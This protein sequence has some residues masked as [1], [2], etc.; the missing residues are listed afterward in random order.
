M[1]IWLPR[2]PLDRLVRRQDPRVSGVFAVTREIKNAKRLTHIS[3]AGVRAGLNPGMS[4]TD[5]RA[6]CPD[7]LTE[8]ADPVRE[9]LLLRALRRW[10]DRLSPWAALDGPDGLVLDISGCA[11]LYAGEDPMRAEAMAQLADMHITAQIAIADTQGA[12]WALARYGYE[13]FIAPPGRIAEAISDL[14]V[15]ALRIDPTAAISLRRIGL[16]RI[17]SLSAI[18]G[19]DL[20]RRYGLAFNQRR[21]KVLGHVPDP[22]A[23]LAADQ[24]FAARMNLPEP[25]GLQS[26]IEAVL[27]RLCISVC[28]RLERACQGARGF[29]L[30]VRCVDTGEHFLPIGFARPT[31]DI[32]LIKRQFE[33][34]LDDLRMEFGA[35]WFR[36][37]ARDVEPLKIIQ[38]DIE[39]QE[40]DEES[41]D[42]MIA[43][44]GNRLGFDRVRRFAPR[45]SHI[46]ER[47]FA[48]VEAVCVVDH[49]EWEPAERSRPLRLFRPERL[50]T[51]E[52]GRPPKR[53]SWRGQTYETRSAEGP[54]RLSPEW[55]QAVSAPVRDY[56]RVQ[57]GEGPRLWL[58]AHPSRTPPEWFVAG[59]FT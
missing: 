2:L 36:L 38:R 29:L 19:S 4:A 24:V 50:Q 52:P 49:P 43:M 47:E 53:F 16:D 39:G 55:W 32:R 45:D 41:L 22:V 21:E 17:G 46:P 57:T 34:P 15:E 56:W 27:E 3:E 8:P 9:D 28:E 25:I 26:D 44:L 10:A 1:S 59:Q 42:Q 11:H 35:D 14:P 12:A 23:P 33:K 6:L 37:I 40:V 48:S 18:K 7:L 31:H 5:A 58:M 13:Q 54:E 51:L 20:A 30:T